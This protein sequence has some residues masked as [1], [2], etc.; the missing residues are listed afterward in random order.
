MTPSTNFFL[1]GGNS[2]LVIRLQAQIRKVFGITVPLVKLLGASTLGEMTAVIEEEAS[3]DGQL[4]INWE[5]ETR[6]PIVPEFLLEVKDASKILKDKNKKTF[7]VTGATGFTAGYLLPRLAAREDVERI[8]CVAL[9]EKQRDSDLFTSP[10]VVYH[11]GDLSEPLLGMTQDDI[12]SLVGNVDV[13]VHLGAT[14]GFFDN[15]HVLRPS[16][17]HPTRELVKLATFRQIPIH[18]ISTIGVLPRAV[19]SDAISAAN[20][21]PSAD[22]KDGYIASKW[23]SERILER[24]AE[25]LGVPSTIYRLVPSK[26]EKQGVNAK[27]ELLNEL[28]RLVGMSGK[29]PDTRGWSGRV[30][31]VPGEHLAH[32][33]EAIFTGANSTAST[34]QISHFESPISL[35]AEELRV[36]IE[37]Q[38]REGLERLPLLKWFGR[39]KSHGFSYLLTSQDTTVNT[40][41]NDQAVFESRR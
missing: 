8:H 34:A 13:I 16:N 37:E 40:G 41:G 4:K 35:D 9:R 27:E 31:F 30:D 2:L 32:W 24:S 26:Q 23:A 38:R 36:T 18:Y 29:I 7:L 25:D 15:Y 33:L 20:Y 28:G 3:A 6:P 39:I 11:G 10:K 19:A 22:G 14:R 5:L 12:L 21:V 17:V 1:V